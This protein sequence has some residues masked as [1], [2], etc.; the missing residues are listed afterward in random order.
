MLKIGDFSKLTRISIRMLRHYDEI[1][2]LIPKE[3]D[4]L[5][6][7]RYYSEKQLVVANKINAL[8][9]MGF[10][11]ANIILIINQQDQNN[12]IENSL[13]EKYEEVNKQL[14]ETTQRLRLLKTAILRLENGDNI[15]NYEVTLKTLPQRYVASVRKT[16]PSYQQE[17][18][19]W[20]IMIKETYG[21]NIKDSDSNCALAIFHDCEYKESDVD[22]EIQKNVVGSIENTKNVI[23]K[24]VEPI[25]FACST[26]I[27]PYDKMSEVNLCVANW[28]NDNGYDFNGPSFFIYHVSPNDTQNPDEFVTEIC[29]PVIKK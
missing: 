28:V 1:G 27:G 5:T 7:Y 24:T 22:V 15:M 11:L 8:K 14:I 26:I 17:G 16:I 10:S 13:S 21:L 19:L 20:E 6:N 29:L 4:D 12:F 2:L 23:F 9:D 25:Q 18:M 3:I